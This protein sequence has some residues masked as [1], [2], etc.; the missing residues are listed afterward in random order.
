MDSE[1]MDLINVIEISVIANVE[2]RQECNI[3]DLIS[4]DIF[5]RSIFQRMCMF[6]GQLSRPV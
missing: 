5:G 4:F 1:L 6:P 2:V 3:P